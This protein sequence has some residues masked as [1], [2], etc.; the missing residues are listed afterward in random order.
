[1]PSRFK[2]A[3]QALRTYSGFPLIAHELPAGIANIGELGSQE[4]ALPLALQPSAQQFFI[5]VR[6]V[7]IRRVVEI[8]PNSSARSSVASDS[9]HRAPRKTRSS[10][11]SPNQWRRPQARP[12]PNGVFSYWLLYWFGFEQPAIDALESGCRPRPARRNCFAAGSNVP[13]KC[14]ENPDRVR[15]TTSARLTQDPSG[16]I[17][18][19]HD[20]RTHSQR[21]RFLPTSTLVQYLRRMRLTATEYAPVPASRNSHSPA[22]A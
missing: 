11:C 7:N 8:D 12:S 2:L 13:L 1:M 20:L 16:G 21:K 17:A 3:S 10:P 9:G 5:G 15:A 18:D 14:P 4:Y 6:P 19:Y 22:L